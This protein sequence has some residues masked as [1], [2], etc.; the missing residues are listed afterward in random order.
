MEALHDVDVSYHRD[1][2]T[3]EGH[4]V[5][6]DLNAD[7]IDVERISVSG[8][9]GTVTGSA[10]LNRDLL[11]VDA[12]GENV[13]LAAIGRALGLPRGTLDGTLRVDASLTTG[14]D[15]TRGHVRLGLRNGTV[16]PVG[17]ASLQLSADLDGRSLKGN[18]SGL[19]AG[20]GTFGATWD[21][22][23]GG[24][25]L[26]V[27]SWK[28]AT[29]SAEVQ[30]GDVKLGLL[31]A[32]LP[33]SSPGDASRRASLRARPPRAKDGQIPL[34]QMCPP[35][36]P[37]ASSRS[38]SRRRTKEESDR[39][40][41]SDGDRDAGRDD[42][43]RHSGDAYAADNQGDLF[44]ISGVRSGP[45]SNA[46]FDLPKAALEKLWE[47]PARHAPWCRSRG[48]TCATL[49]PS[50]CDRRRRH[51]GRSARTCGCEERPGAPDR[52][53]AAPMGSRSAPRAAAAPPTFTRTHSTMS[54]RAP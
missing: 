30:V 22:A 12:A 33:K 49:P 15:V 53:A 7:N 11:E 28:T 27:A 17:G 16:G 5:S 47:T 21:G 26:E 3:I 29:G 38:S 32:L 46:C 39:R 42:G 13:D 18:A 50:S 44:A 31:G 25:P 34:S 1:P 43:R 19:V 48:G 8:A 54:R 52:R 40:H 45:T 23:L 9:G 35:P 6:L 37:P 36:L 20:L 14:K 2:V 10:R 51:R 41:R 4:V 24:R